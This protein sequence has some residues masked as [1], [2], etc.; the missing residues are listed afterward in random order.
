MMVS[1]EAWTI[2]TEKSLA[3]LRLASVTGGVCALDLVHTDNV[4]ARAHLIA[5]APELLEACKEAVAKFVD[6]D[7]CDDCG[8]KGHNPDCVIAGLQAATAKAEGSA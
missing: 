8:R 6:V 4:E 7:W 1:E 2:V 5:A 3:D